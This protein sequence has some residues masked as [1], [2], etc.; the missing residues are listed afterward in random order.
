[1]DKADIVI[2]IG[3]LLLLSAITY[4]L[5]GLVILPGFL[6]CIIGVSKKT[7]NNKQWK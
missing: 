4:G 2:I 1:M 6:C 7:N 5:N 3:E